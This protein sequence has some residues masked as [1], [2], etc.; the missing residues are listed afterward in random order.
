MEERRR[1]E[2]KF[3]NDRANFINNHYK[4]HNFTSIGDVDMYGN[5]SNSYGAP[6]KGGNYNQ[7]S[8]GPNPPMN[9][10]GGTDMS[11]TPSAPRPMVV[12]E[13]CCCSVM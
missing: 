10:T 7:S 5:N 1:G 13:S 8:R 3:M 4:Q 6:V 2:Q 9:T 12:S 11:F